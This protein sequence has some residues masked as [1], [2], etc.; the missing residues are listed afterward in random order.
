MWCSVRR[1][2]PLCVCV[3]LRCQTENLPSETV[4]SFLSIYET[5]K[6]IFQ[7]GK[8]FLVLRTHGTRV[9]VSRKEENKAVSDN[10]R[11]AISCL[12]KYPTVP[13]QKNPA[14]LTSG[15][16]AQCYQRTHTQGEK[17]KRC[18]LL[19]VQPNRAQGADAKSGWGL[20]VL[21]WRGSD[22]R[23]PMR[24]S[25]EV[26]ALTDGLLGGYILHITLRRYI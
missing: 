14:A 1:L 6:T 25:R 22:L 2:H 3:K 16:S 17:S 26:V 11:T 12:C 20:C 24:E 8:W 15:K 10:R 18:A 5:K 7:V 19:G 21:F 23:Q 13:P 4:G 9:T